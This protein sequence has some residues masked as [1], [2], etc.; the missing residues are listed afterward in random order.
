MNTLEDYFKEALTHDVIDHSLRAHVNGDGKPQFYIHPAGA[1]GSTVDFVV[2]GN[3][4]TPAAMQKAPPEQN[5]KC[6]HA[7]RDGECGWEH[8]PQLRDGEPAKSG[9]TC[10]L[11]WQEKDEE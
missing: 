1:D 6:C 5:N 4:V 3:T 7:A 11:P 9:R 8:C 2:D 10:P